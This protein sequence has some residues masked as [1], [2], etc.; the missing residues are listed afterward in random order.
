M[1]TG[2]FANGILST[3]GHGIVHDLQVSPDGRTATITQ[4]MAA[5]LAGPGAEM[6][7]PKA[8]GQVTFSQRLVIDLEA[9]IPTVTD[10][11][12][13]QTLA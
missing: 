10:F 3:F 13:S 6:T 4:T 5:D 11:Q 1:T 7:D 12:L 8:F 9:E 2:T